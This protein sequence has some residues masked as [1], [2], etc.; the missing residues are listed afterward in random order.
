MTMTNIDMNFLAPIL[1]RPGFDAE[2]R[3]HTPGYAK[4]SWGAQGQLTEPI[5]LYDLWHEIATTSGPSPGGDFS[6]EVAELTSV[7]D[8]LIPVYQDRVEYLADTI[9]HVASHLE[10]A[11]T[12]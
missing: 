3:H 1:S 8:G 7:R 9:D 4:I 6:A 2:Q 5:D 10:D 12:C 11:A